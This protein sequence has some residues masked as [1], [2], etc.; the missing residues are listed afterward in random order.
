MESQ[1]DNYSGQ[2][3][4]SCLDLFDNTWL[5]DGNILLPALTFR[6]HTK[7]SVSGCIDDSPIISIS[8]KRYTHI[9][10]CMYGIPVYV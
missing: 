9:L 8:I 3:F 7:I 6:L 2:F 1:I 4:G 10:G 5:D